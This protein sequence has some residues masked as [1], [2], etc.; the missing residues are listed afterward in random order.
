[1]AL[2]GDQGFKDEVMLLYLKK[3]LGKE[4]Q[5]LL[6]GLTSMKEAW[7]RLDECF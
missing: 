4:A 3:S 6:T 2:L 1:M 5:Q 7:T